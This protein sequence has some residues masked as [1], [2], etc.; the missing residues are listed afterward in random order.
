M[1]MKY[2]GARFCDRLRTCIYAHMH[3]VCTPAIIEANTHTRRTCTR[4]HVCAAVCKFM[5]DD[6]RLRICK[7]LSICLT[8]VFSR[9]SGVLVYLFPAAALVEAAGMAAWCPHSPIPSDRGR[10]Q[11]FLSCPPTPTTPGALACPRLVPPPTRPDPVSRQKRKIRSREEGGGKN[12]R[13]WRE[14]KK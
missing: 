2:R 1:I 5:W 13:N 14:M 9:S 12:E 8:C 4:V 6:L 11:S 10:L 3:V 7:Y